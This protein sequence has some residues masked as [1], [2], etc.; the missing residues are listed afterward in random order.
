MSGW[1]KLASDEGK[2]IHAQEIHSGAPTRE[3]VPH[4]QIKQA[5]GFRQFSLR[6]REKVTA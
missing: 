6:G 3:R 5:R 2:A 1:A 4:G